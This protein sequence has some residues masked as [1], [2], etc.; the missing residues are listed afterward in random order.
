MATL[1]EQY[2]IKA[3]NR[4]LAIAQAE[5]ADAEAKINALAATVDAQIQTDGSIFIHIPNSGTSI[6]TYKAVTSY[7]GQK[8]LTSPAMG[9]RLDIQTTHVVIWWASLEQLNAALENAIN[10][11]PVT[12]NPTV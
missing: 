12:P 4:K 6:P 9:F 11:P 10:P 3:Y 5:K 2:A 1:A 8:Y 7:W